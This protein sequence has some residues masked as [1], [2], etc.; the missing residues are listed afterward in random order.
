MIFN[1]CEENRK[2][3]V[4]GNPT[5]NGIDYLE[6]LD[7]AAIPARKPAAADAAGH[8]LKPAPPTLTAE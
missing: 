8:C 1:C 2:A 6:V 5:I 3:A 4:A 7:H